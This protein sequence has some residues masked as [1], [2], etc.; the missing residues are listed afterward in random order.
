MPRG[1]IE[2]LPSV[3]WVSTPIVRDFFKISTSSIPL[4]YENAILNVLLTFTLIPMGLYDE[5][6]WLGYKVLFTPS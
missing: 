2:C 5:I 4:L 1:I 6:V 3:G